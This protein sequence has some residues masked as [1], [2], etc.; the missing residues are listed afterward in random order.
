LHLDLRADNLLLSKKE[1]VLVV[2]WPHARV[3]IP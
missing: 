1:R 3:G 2:D